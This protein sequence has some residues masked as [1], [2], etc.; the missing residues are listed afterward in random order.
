[1]E[2]AR[3]YQQRRS[4]RAQEPKQREANWKDDDKTHRREGKPARD[5]GQLGQIEW[6]SL[7]GQ[8]GGP[9]Q[10][11]IIHAR[12]IHQRELFD[13]DAAATALARR[14]DGG[15]PARPRVNGSDGSDRVTSVPIA[16]RARHRRL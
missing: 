4:G 5:C 12:R 6:R 13:V 16:R 2:E 3:Q 10:Y 14:T 1:M 7:A 11:V 9:F 8:R 15:P